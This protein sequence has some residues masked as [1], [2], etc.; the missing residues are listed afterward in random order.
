VSEHD[1]NTEDLMTPMTLENI[2]SEL[3]LFKCLSDEGIAPAITMEPYIMFTL[4]KS[5]VGL[6]MNGLRVE[7]AAA[8]PVLVE[9][10][11]ATTLNTVQPPI[12]GLPQIT[13]KA[14]I[15]SID[16]RT[17]M[18]PC[19]QVRRSSGDKVVVQEVVRSY[20]S[21][22]IVLDKQEKAALDSKKARSGFNRGLSSQVIARSRVPRDAITYRGVLCM[23]RYDGELDD[24][25]LDDISEGMAQ[26]IK[27]KIEELVTRMIDLGVVC[28]DVNHHNIMLKNRGDGNVDVRLIDF[29]VYCEVD[30]IGVPTDFLRGMLLAMLAITTEFR[31]LR[32]W[33]IDFAALP[34]YNRHIRRF[35]NSEHSMV[36]KHWTESED[37]DSVVRAYLN[38]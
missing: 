1:R 31:R 21:D 9:G 3:A 38:R 28:T 17:T 8:H 22:R 23:E 7:L 35:Q 11:L 10:L 34:S 16:T 15:D 19:V 37:V 5:S 24:S 32:S 2:A 18:S 27:T 14:Y 4:G 29:G 33:V 6:L 12:V 26:S 13:P 25:R 30:E 20:S 36:F